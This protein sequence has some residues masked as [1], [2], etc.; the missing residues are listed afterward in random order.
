MLLFRAAT[1]MYSKPNEVNVTKE[2]ELVIVTVM[3]S[4][5]MASLQYTCPLMID[6][7]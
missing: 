2:G 7:G 6:Y 1:T 5:L 3:T 4:D